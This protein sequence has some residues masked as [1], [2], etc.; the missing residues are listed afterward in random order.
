M[1]KAVLFGAIGIVAAGASAQ[2]MNFDANLANWGADDPN[3]NG[4]GD[5]AVIYQT[6]F[7]LPAI[8][9]IDSAYF[10][11]A[12]SF[13]SDMHLTLQ[14]PNGDLFL[15]A[16][17][18]DAANEPPYNAPFDGGDLGDG[19]SELAGVERYF[20]AENGSVWNDGDGGTAPLPGDTHES[21]DWFSGP[22][23]A[24]SWTLTVEDAWDTA[25]DG[26]LGS[27]GVNYTVPAPGA[28]ALLGLGGLAAI[29]R[30]R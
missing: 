9:S 10:D 2:T 30:R 7:D 27:L 4:T 3:G 18:R 25:D 15:F 19:G 17:G 28:V 24:G 14:A 1:T 12:H 5:A 29:R 22:Y 21:I 6:T 23:A 13:L 16:R 8:Q 11:F 20:F 26:A